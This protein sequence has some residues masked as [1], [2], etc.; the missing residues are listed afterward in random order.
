MKKLDASQKQHYAKKD[1]GI[2]ED[3]WDNYL[4][5]DAKH[6]IHLICHEESMP[7]AE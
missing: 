2:N 5:H 7:I 4:F 6:L 1:F 3:P